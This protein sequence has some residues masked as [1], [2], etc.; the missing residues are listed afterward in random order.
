MS[1]FRTRTCRLADPAARV[2]AVV[3]AARSGQGEA[4]GRDRA[5][6]WELE[7]FLLISLIS[8]W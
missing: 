5:W 2:T 8:S 7:S 4:A 3:A 1:A 6:P